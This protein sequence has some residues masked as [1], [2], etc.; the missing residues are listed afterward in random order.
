MF[1]IVGLS[2]VAVGLWLGRAPET[3]ERPVLGDLI[4]NSS[5]IHY[6]PAESREIQL[7]MPSTRSRAANA[8]R[9]QADDLAQDQADEIL[10][11]WRKAIA[12]SDSAE[13][14]LVA[15][16]LE[17]DA[18][19][20]ETLLLEA[21]RLDP[22]N[23]LINFMVAE[24]CLGAVNST[25]C[26]PELFD[27]LESLDGDNG[28]VHDLK[29]IQ[30]YR[31]GD[32]DGA[33]QSLMA[34]SSSTITDAYEWQHMAAV[35]ESL[36]SLGLERDAHFLKSVNDYADKRSGE[37]KA[38][39]MSMCEQQ[40]TSESW[41]QQCADRG[42]SMMENELSLDGRFFGFGLAVAASDNPEVFQQ[43]YLKTLEMESQ[44]MAHFISEVNARPDF[45]MNETQWSEYLAVYGKEGEKAAMG[46]LAELGGE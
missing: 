6:L 23:P 13:E 10:D 8:E 46:Y 2:I 21:L 39:L 42:K 16:T 1:I 30:A 20:R 28:A 14:L 31:N 34:A 26:S 5:H 29:A 36:G 12:T 32:I 27:V 22:Y 41:Q 19:K 18:D 7:S 15:A 35:A 3:L 43:D 25:Q 24:H 45:S 37:R 40:R 17:A 33:A 11:D 38:I 44:Q 9:V 4:N